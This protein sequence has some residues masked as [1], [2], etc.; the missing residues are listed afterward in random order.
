MAY[1]SNS[2]NIELNRGDSL[3]LDILVNIGTTLEKNIYKLT[4][5]DAVYFGLM[6]PNQPFECAIVKKKLSLNDQNEK[7]VMTLRLVPDDTLCLLPG[8]YF[9]QVKLAIHPDTVITLIDKSQF[10]IL[11]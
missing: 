9:Y 1:V 8:K 6:E 10:F 2:G 4:E 7:G 11:E 5:N 3:G